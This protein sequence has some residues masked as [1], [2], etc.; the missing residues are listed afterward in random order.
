MAAGDYTVAN[1][2]A[3]V[4]RRAMIPNSTTVLSDADITSFLNHLTLHSIRH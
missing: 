3:D 4:R 2:V 1:L